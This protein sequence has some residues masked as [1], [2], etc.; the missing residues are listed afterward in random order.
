MNLVRIVSA[1]TSHLRLLIEARLWDFD[2]RD[3][4]ITASA[5]PFK[6]DERACE[7]ARG[8]P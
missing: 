8:P 6:E 5:F 4:A 3:P 7:R 2:M 1:E